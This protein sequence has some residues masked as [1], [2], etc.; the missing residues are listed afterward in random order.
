M[1]Y[2]VK[3]HKKFDEI[4]FQQVVNPNFNKILFQC[5]HITL[6]RKKTLKKLYLEINLKKEMA[7][8]LYK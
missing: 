3:A 7:K 5:I 1:V 4:L 6:V 8:K 2:N